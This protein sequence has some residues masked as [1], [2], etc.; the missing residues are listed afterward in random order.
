MNQYRFECDWCLIE[1]EDTLDRNVMWSLYDNNNFLV[2]GGY[3]QAAHDTAT[4][5]LQILSKMHHDAVNDI[6]HSNYSFINNN[7]QEI[8]SLLSDTINN[9]IRWVN[10]RTRDITDGE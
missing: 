9:S 5:V 10:T 8:E 4:D 2:D 6:T 7:K 3:K 1:M